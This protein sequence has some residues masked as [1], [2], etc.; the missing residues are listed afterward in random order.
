MLVALIIF[1]CGND[2]PKVEI[3]RATKKLTGY[4]LDFIC[5]GQPPVAVSG[6]ISRVC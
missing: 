3:R 6:G 2:A 5:L 4:F 1:A